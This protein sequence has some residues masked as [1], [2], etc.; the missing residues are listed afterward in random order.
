MPE[1]T[2]AEPNQD[3]VR[4]FIEIIQIRQTRGFIVIS[5]LQSCTVQIE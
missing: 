3:G 1:L 5:N 2:S 4:S